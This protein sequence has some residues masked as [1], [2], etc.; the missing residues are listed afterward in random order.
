VALLVEDERVA[1]EDQL[2]LPSDGVAE[3]DEAR[4]VAGAGGEHLPALAIPADVERRS[5]DVGQQLRPGQRQ[6][7]GG[8]ARLPHVLA[9]GRPD[10][11]AAEL[12]E[13]AVARGREVAVFVEDPVVRQEPLAVDG[14]HLAAG[15]DGAGVVEVAVEVG[16]VDERDG[17]VRGAGDRVQRLVCRAHEP[18]PQ[19]QVLGR[20]TG[21]GELREE[22]EVGLGAAGLLDR[23][24][25][26]R[27]VAVEV[28]D[29]GVD[30][31]ERDSHLVVLDYQSKTYP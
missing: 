24:E 12:E 26:S 21:D 31:C 10:Q 25:D 11:R 5:G 22:D 8:R 20:V 27:A 29:G 18:R 17:V 6:V 4:V 15:A 23:L 13:Q 28:A 16:E 30:L 7:G 9:D 19:Q 1:V 2:V 14:L 3:S